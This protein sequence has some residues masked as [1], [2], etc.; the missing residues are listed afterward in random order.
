LRLLSKNKTQAKCKRKQFQ[1]DD[2]MPKSQ[3]ATLAQQLCKRVL[4]T[5]RDVDADA[6]I[7]SV[8]KWDHDCS[9]LVRV[10]A[11]RGAAFGILDALKSS[12]PL[13]RVSLVENVMDGTTEAQMLVPSRCEQHEI[14]RQQAFE[15]HTAK[16]LRTFIKL[17]ALATL[18][19]FIVSVTTNAIR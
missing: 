10:R 6:S 3:P 13:A 16:R 9:T 11:G 8:S 12:W 14:A 19:S 1:M 15:S 7:A 2:Q 17:T 18:L 4:S 5:V